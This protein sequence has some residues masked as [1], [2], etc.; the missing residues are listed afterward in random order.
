[1]QINFVRSILIAL[2]V[3]IHLVP[4]K[5]QHPD[6]QRAVLGFVVP[7]FLFI[8][9][10]LVNVN[11]PIGKFL[12]YLLAIALPYAI[13]EA[14]YLF[15]SMYVPVNF[16]P[17]IHGANDVIDIMLVHPVG[18]YWY[19]HTMLICGAVYYAVFRYVKSNR[20]YVLAFLLTTIAYFTPLLG[21]GPVV[22][23][24][25]GVVARQSKMEI[26]RLFPPTPWALLTFAAT[27]VYVLYLDN[28][29]TAWESLYTI[30][31]S[32]SMMSFA[33]WLSS[34]VKFINVFDYI[35]RNTLPIYIFHPIF[36][37]IAKKSFGALLSVD[38]SATL[39]A[40]CTVTLAVA[41]SLALAYVLDMT[42][43]S[44]IFGRRRLL[45]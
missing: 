23:Y 10:Y 22:A 13:M 26:E 41:G 34:R 43:L 2:V 16:V 44:R 19:L 27:L 12:K 5:A 9:G 31:M 18:P 39:Y 25:A 28:S 24:V 36:T 29:F 3:F 4:F 33:V 20:M 30:I 17:E 45:R 7:L 32:V 38:S 15:V 35:G 11:K 1:M 42:S 21:I 8:T 6:L 37:M 40:V 14:G